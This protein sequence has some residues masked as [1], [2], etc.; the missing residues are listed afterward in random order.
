MSVNHKRTG[1]EAGAGTGEQAQTEITALR[2]EIADLK[3][4]GEKTA[5]FLSAIFQ[6][7]LAA[8]RMSKTSIITDDVIQLAAEVAALSEVK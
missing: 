5:A 4:T 7:Q 3:A 8:D 2:E 1:G 6:N